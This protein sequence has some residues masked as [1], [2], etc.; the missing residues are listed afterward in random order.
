M[1]LITVGCG[2]VP[3][4]Q[5][6]RPAPELVGVWY[7]VQAG[8]TADKI[9]R[10]YKIPVQDLR[11]LNGLTAGQDPKPG[12]VIFLYGVERLLREKKRSP[13]AVSKKKN[14]RG[15][16][17]VQPRKKHKTTKYVW[18][19]RKGVLSSGYGKRG[20]RMH[21]GIDIAAKPGTPIYATADGK[22]IYSDNKQRGYGNLVILEHANKVVTVY[23]HNR[24]NLVDVGQTVRQGSQIA[25]VGN[26]GRS[27]GP[28]L[29]FE[30]RVRGKARDP[31]R[32]LPAR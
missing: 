13:R 8:D 27:T 4:M 6:R 18:P 24:R 11:E 26:T 9:A 31:L 10:V 3:Q 19:V 20:R 28:H 2:G 32:Y 7:T 22:V 23:A 12:K 17:R 15:K 30:I 14:L 1:L 25:E 5:K 21:K 16:K 29:H